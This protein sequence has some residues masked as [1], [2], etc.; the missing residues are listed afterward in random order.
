MGYGCR[1]LQDLSGSWW[2]SPHSTGTCVYLPRRLGKESTFITASAR[3]WEMVSQEAKGHCRPG[4][5][6]V[7]PVH[8][9]G[10]TL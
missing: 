3:G 5:G 4:M 2:A 1:R 9:A 7:V 10:V 6:T 8:G